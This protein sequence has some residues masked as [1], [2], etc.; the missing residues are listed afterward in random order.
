LP[1]E[2]GRISR[3]G[4]GVAGD[5]DRTKEDAR[6]DPRYQSHHGLASE[7]PGNSSLHDY[8]Q[9]MADLDT[10][11]RLHN[12]TQ[13]KN[14]PALLTPVSMASVTEPDLRSGR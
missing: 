10:I 11:R 14:A 4:S 8:L 13:K 12:E 1:I 3:T 5:Q 9:I 2:F 6:E 7:I